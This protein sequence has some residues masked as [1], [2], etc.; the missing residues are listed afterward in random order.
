MP[1]Q[2]QVQYR[3]HRA[4]VWIVA[5]LVVGYTLMGFVVTPIVVQHLLETKG[6]QHL[7]PGHPHQDGCPAGR[8]GRFQ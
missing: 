1:R 6:S 5:G 4:L 2:L 8:Q 3:Q 7:H